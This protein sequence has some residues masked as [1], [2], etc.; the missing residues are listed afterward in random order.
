MWGSE[1]II[2]S[3]TVAIKWVIVALALFKKLRI[4]EVSLN[5]EQS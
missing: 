5:F 2:L 1:P 3:C 4:L